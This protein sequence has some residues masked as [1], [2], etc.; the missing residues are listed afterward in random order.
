MFLGHLLPSWFSE[1]PEEQ[2]N[3]SAIKIS[4]HV[5][6]FMKSANQSLLPASPPL[7]KIKIEEEENNNKEQGKKCKKEKKKGV[8]HWYSFFIFNNTLISDAYTFACLLMLAC[9]SQLT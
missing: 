5:A 3:N 4:G 6:D 8:Y 1:R 2:L 9:A 7:S